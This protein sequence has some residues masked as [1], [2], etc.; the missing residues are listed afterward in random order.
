MLHFEIPEQD[1][2]AIHPRDV[3][4]IHG[5]LLKAKNKLEEGAQAALGKGLKIY[6]KAGR[7]PYADHNDHALIVDTKSGHRYLVALSMPDK[8]GKKPIVDA[9]ITEMT[10]HALRIVK[11][12]SLKEIALTRNWGVP[13]EIVASTEKPGLITAQVK[14][15][16][17][18]D[19]LELWKD[20]ELVAEV[21]GDSLETAL[22]I[23]KKGPVL[24]IARAFQKGKHAGYRLAAFTY[25]SDNFT[26][27][28]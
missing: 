22:S 26:A 4:R 2:F 14:C 7:L 28:P 15:N 10:K 13:I 16:E 17:G 20:S 1:R 3:R 8:T 9:Q 27:V 21:K 11:N 6:N 5:Y 24:L 18:C 25:P 12:Q 19:R 23:S